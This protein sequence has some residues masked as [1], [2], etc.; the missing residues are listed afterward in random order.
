MECSVKGSGS[1]NLNRYKIAKIRD[2]SFGLISEP[3]ICTVCKRWGTVD[4]NGKYQWKYYHEM[5]P[6]EQSQVNDI[7][8][9]STGAT[10]FRSEICEDC[11]T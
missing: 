8:R 7:K 5:L 11:Q 3:I 2:L 6:E 9:E 10:K 1:R 4:E